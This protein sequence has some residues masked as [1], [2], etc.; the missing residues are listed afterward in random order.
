MDIKVYNFAKEPNSTKQP[1][2]SAG[3]TIQNIHLKGDCSFMHPVFLLDGWQATDNYVKWGSRYYWIEDMIILSKTQAEYHCREDVLASFRSYIG[4]SSQYI[5]RCAKSFTTGIIDTKYPLLTTFTRTETELTTF[6]NSMMGGGFYVVGI[7][8]GVT[9][10]GGGITYYAMNSAQFGS[11]VAFMYAGTWLDTTETNVTIALQKELI[12]PMQYVSSIIWFPFDYSMFTGSTVESVK[13]GWWQGDAQ[14]T[15]VRLSSGQFVKS[16]VSSAISLPRHSE[17]ATRGTY[18][19]S[20]PYTRH[21]LFAY[22]FGEIPIDAMQFG[23][24]ASMMVGITADLS[25][26]DAKLSIFDADAKLIDIHYG[27][28]GQ[29]IPISQIRQSLIAPVAN[30]ISGATGLRYGNVVGFGQGIVSAAEAMMPQA[31][32]SGG[33]DSRLW[34][35][36]VPTILTECHNIASEDRDHLG[37]PLCIRGIIQNYADASHNYI[38]VENADID[39]ACNYSEL[40]EIKG[41]M[42]SGFYYE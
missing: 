32:R 7:Q 10:D 27:K 24:S 4:S 20:Q 29:A 21:T 5:T 9:S 42:E 34:Y 12:N 2:S 36:K 13:F 41:F 31:E 16:W 25:T 19:N 14:A 3:R 38:E 28:M 40:E 1:G 26:G 37:R 23:S 35:Y 33:T 11:F 17:A 22:T 39:F 15:G 8:N 30:I 18:L 6:H